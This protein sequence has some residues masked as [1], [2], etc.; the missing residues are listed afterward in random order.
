[1]RRDRYRKRWGSVTADVA[2]FRYAGTV[3]AREMRHSFCET[4]P[5][6]F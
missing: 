4:A 2:A 5:I 3:V 1:M 6:G